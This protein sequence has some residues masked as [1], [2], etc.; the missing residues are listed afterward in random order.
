MNNF[1]LPPA[2]MLI[3][4]ATVILF[5]DRVDLEGVNFGT[6]ILKVRCKRS[7]A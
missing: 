4:I 2:F 1:Q 7:Q 6:A 5:G 3:F